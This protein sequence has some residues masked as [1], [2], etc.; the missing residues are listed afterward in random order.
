MNNRKYTNAITI[1]ELSIVLVIISLIVTVT[2]AG[3]SLVRASEIKTMIGKVNNLK[4][5]MGQFKNMYNKLPGDIDNATNFWQDT[6]NGNGNGKIEEDNNETMIALQHLKLAGVIKGTFSNTNNKF[7]END[8]N[9]MKLDL[10]NSSLYIRCCSKTDYQRNLDFLNHIAVF[11]IASDSKTRQG[12]LTPIEAFELDKKI[13]D[14]NPDTGF[15]GAEGEYNNGS[16]GS[17][18]CYSN[19][20]KDAF[21]ESNNKE[22]K[23]LA[24][25]QMFF[26]Y[27]W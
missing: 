24:G 9:I 25:C 11:S 2:I 14:G 18:A 8:K 23:D 3:Q 5:A 26:A 16:Y 17:K 6:I 22:Y 21:Y 1:L 19:I 15:V 27:D 13:D 12:A 7:Y 4:S 20:G 10:K